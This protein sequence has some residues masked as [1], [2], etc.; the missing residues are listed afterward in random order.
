M[1]RFFM[2][3]F[4]RF[5]IVLEASDTSK[6]YGAMTVAVPASPDD[7]RR[8]LCRNGNGTISQGETSD[9]VGDSGKR[10][11]GTHCVR[12]YPTLFSS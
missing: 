8:Q 5:R 3:A 1:G 9:A 11:H 7:E 2:S 12:H 4:P 10:Y 6:E